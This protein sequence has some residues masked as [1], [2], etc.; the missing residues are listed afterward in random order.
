MNKKRIVRDGWLAGFCWTERSG[1]GGQQKGGH[2]FF[3]YLDLLVPALKSYLCNSLK[4][5]LHFCCLHYTNISNMYI[6]NSKV[7]AIQL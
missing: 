2:Q 3:Y 4:S 1:G 6:V 5:K 7:K